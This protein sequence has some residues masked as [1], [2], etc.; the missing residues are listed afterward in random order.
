MRT[1]PLFFVLVLA[2]GC[3]VTRD[4][5]AA[6][7]GAS[8]AFFDAVA[9]TFSASVTADAALTEQSKKNRLG[10]VEDYHR[11]LRAAEERVR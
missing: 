8:R 11:A 6:F 7:V 10:V 5:R 4:E 1:L 9:P 3:C 2:S